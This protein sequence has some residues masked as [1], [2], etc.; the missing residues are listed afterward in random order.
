[1]PKAYWIARMDVRDPDEYAKYVAGTK[2]AFAKYKAH[3]LV[4]GGE[5]ESLEGQE[6]TRNVVIEF[7][8]R[9]TALACY[10]SPE[11][12]AAKAFRAAASAGELLIVDGYDGPQPGE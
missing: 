7:P 6:R 9:E 1:M 10:N 4:R 3:F 2:A 8:D 12:Q 5:F 11:Y